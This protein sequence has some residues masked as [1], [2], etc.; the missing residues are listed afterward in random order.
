[1][2][3]LRFEKENFAIMKLRSPVVGR[4]IVL[5]L[6]GCTEESKHR[7]AVFPLGTQGPHLLRRKHG[8]DPAWSY[9]PK[10]WNWGTA[11]EHSRKRKTQSKWKETFSPSWGRQWSEM[12][13]WI[14]LSGRDPVFPDTGVIW[15]LAGR[16]SLLWQNTLECFVWSC[17]NCWGI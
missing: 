16:L 4:W 8:A 14:G 6:V 7:A 5:L 11:Q 12:G 2:M 13:L 10:L 1:M 3:N 9:L 15:W 17:C